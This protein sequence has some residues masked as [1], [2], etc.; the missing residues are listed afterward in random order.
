[1]CLIGLK[2][3]GKIESKRVGFSPPEIPALGGLLLK[4]LKNLPDRDRIVAFRLGVAAFERVAKSPIPALIVPK[5]RRY[6]TKIRIRK[7]KNRIPINT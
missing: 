4:E 2:I 5:S 7:N 1:M 3:S 6:P